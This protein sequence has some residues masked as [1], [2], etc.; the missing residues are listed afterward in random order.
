MEGVDAR[1]NKFTSDA[2][3][4]SPLT[5]H[6]KLSMILKDKFVVQ[7]CEEGVGFGHLV[8]KV[9]EEAWHSAWP[10]RI[11]DTDLIS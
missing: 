11:Q 3:L 6:I 9:S 1:K 4:S 8:D 10:P 7:G 2:R 5:R